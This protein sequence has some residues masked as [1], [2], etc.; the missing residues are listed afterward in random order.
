MEFHRYN[1]SRLAAADLHQSDAR[2]S[3]KRS[4]PG[5]FSRMSDEGPIAL[6]IRAGK[7]P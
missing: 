4:R 6:P 2:K 5:R 3:Y 1:G 7:I